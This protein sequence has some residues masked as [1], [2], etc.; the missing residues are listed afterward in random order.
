MRPERP[1]VLDP[2]LSQS[3]GSL[4]P[5]AG[6]STKDLESALADISAATAAGQPM[7][8]LLSGIHRDMS[9]ART[10]TPL[11]PELKTLVAVRTTAARALDPLATWT[12][13]L[14][15]RASRGPFVN[16]LGETFWIDTFHLPTLAS[17]VVE[18]LSG[19]RGLV[20]R[21]PI[22][23]QLGAGNRLRLNAGTVW[24][25]ARLFASGRAAND[26]VAMRITG[27]TANIT[28][29]TLTDAGT[30]D[31]EGRVVARAAPQSR[32]HGRTRSRRR[33]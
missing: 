5:G 13:A 20:A 27:G 14:R 23:G 15:P 16:D 3:L 8:S 33:R 24:L 7:D 30:V 19:Q 29:D 10:T 2:A 31:S 4:R 12:R 21:L 18:N 25:P 1:L 26:F 28:G 6:T 17:L 22:R 11:P 32:P 9:A